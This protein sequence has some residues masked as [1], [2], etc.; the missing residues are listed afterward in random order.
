MA[1]S[2][3][4]V[5]AAVQLLMACANELGT[6]QPAPLSTAAAALGLVVIG[7]VEVEG[8]KRIQDAQLLASLDVLGQGSD[9][10]FLRFVLPG[11][12]GFFDQFV[13]Q[14]EVG[15]HV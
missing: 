3:D 6:T 1:D 2:I 14:S 12:L 13:V 11:A 7:E 4:M 5:C 10:F 9:R 15:R 8:A